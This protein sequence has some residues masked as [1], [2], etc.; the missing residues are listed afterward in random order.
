MS[1]P[2]VPTPQPSAPAPL[3]PVTPL[4]P[5]QAVDSGGN[6]IL[7]GSTI[8]IYNC[9][10]VG[11]K[12]DV[13]NRLNVWVIPTLNSIVTSDPKHPLTGQID[14]KALLISGYQ[15]ILV[16]GPAAA[17]TDAEIAAGLTTKDALVATRDANP[18]TPVPLPSNF[19]APSIL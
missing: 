15:C 1:T 16:A 3:A 14:G 9:L 19:L 11:L 8:A 18:V 10:V 6:P 12:P 2:S 5:L 13:N 7:V 4:D 17:A